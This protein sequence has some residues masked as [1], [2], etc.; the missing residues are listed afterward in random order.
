MA[1]WWKLSRLFCRGIFQE[2]DDCLV[3][4]NQATDKVPYDEF[5][6]LTGARGEF[7][8]LGF[9]LRSKAYFH[10]ALV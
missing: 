1:A 10:Q 4:V 5:G 3:V 6:I 2:G 7:V 8:E 9:D